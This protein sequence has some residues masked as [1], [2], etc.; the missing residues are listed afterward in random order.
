MAVISLALIL[1]KFIIKNKRTVVLYLTSEK[2]VILTKALFNTDFFGSI[3]ITEDIEEFI[4]ESRPTT[5]ET[6]L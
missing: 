1:K 4:D 5:S 6:V 2:P 3:T